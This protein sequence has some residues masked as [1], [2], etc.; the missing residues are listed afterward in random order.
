MSIKYLITAD[1]VSHIQPQYDTTIRLAEEL[2]SRGIEV[3]FCDIT[4]MDLALKPDQYLS[5]IHAKPVIHATPDDANFLGLGPEKKTKV[6]D[7]AVIL[8]RKDPPVDDF[9]IQHAHK[10]THAPKSILQINDPLSA[11]SYSEHELPMRYPNYAVPTNITN[12][13]QELVHAARK[14][15]TSG[16]NEI[17][18]KPWATCSGMGVEFLKESD[19]DQ[20]E[21]Y[22]KKWGPKIIVQPFLHE[23]T[24]LGDLRI[25]VF[26][27]KVL[28]SVM[29]VPKP[30]SKLANLHQG[31][32]SRAHTPSKHQLECAAHVARD[33]KPL[34]LYFLGLDFIGEALSE[35]NITSPSALAQVNAVMGIR[36]QVTLVDEIEKLRQSRS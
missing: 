31:A 21:H 15:F 33:L 1:P 9:F 17:V 16:C 4:K 32:S 8:N 13:L 6:G 24:T 36:A 20:F 27:E 34:G 11:I 25:L 2:L 5:H 18:L 23:I 19:Q 7:Y 14:L 35:V 28:G 26:N 10:W 29:R 22:Q 12:S 3:D 30:G